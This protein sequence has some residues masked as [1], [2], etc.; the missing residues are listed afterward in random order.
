MSDCCFDSRTTTL[1]QSNH[2]KYSSTSQSKVNLSEQ[3]NPSKA[4]IANIKRNHS[5][6]SLIGGF[7]FG[8][9]GI[10]S[11]KSYSEKNDQ[12]YEENKSLLP[13]PIAIRKCETVI[14][15]SFLSKYHTQDFTRDM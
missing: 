2:T 10:S 12:I 14:P 6:K 1:N 5:A 11:N 4:N 15:P 8:F 9:R 13:S 7:S 3:K